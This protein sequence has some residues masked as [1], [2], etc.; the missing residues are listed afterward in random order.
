MLKP[1]VASCC[2]LG[3]LAVAI[4]TDSPPAR[5]Q[6]GSCFANFDQEYANFKQSNPMNPNWGSRDTFQ[7]SYFMGEQGINILMKYQSCMDAGDF[8]TNY[9]ALVGLR[10]QGRQGC[11]A[12]NSGARPC[13]PTYPSM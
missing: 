3:A 12:L 5:A 4:V 11:E 10:D 6:G 7:W 2:A 9:E 1:I 8:A 13:T